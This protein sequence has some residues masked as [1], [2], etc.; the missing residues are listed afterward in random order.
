MD[1]GSY[2]LSSAILAPPL[3]PWAIAVLMVAVL[4]ALTLNAMRPAA[5]GSLQKDHVTIV[6]PLV[7]LTFLGKAKLMLK[8]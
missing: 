1:S 8:I 6:L 4:K 7:L 5:S 3:N 2:H